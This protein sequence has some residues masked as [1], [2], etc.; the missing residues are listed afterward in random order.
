MNKQI[1]ALK[2]AIEALESIEL[3]CDDKRWYL[4][5]NARKAC[6]E[7]LEHP[8]K[9][10]AAGGEGQP[11]QKVKVLYEK[12]GI[13]TCEILPASSWQSLSDDEIFE[14]SIREFTKYEFARAIEQA[15]KEKNQ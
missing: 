3:L 5:G 10:W 1:E 14:L 6:K 11:A 9:D 4:I 2:M 15:L 7:A 12:D 8:E 13:Q